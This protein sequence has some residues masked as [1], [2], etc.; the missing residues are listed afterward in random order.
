MKNIK[1]CIRADF[2]C[3]WS[4]PDEIVTLYKGYKKRDIQINECL[5]LFS[6]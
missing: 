5:F 6:T 4:I 2:F 1:G 3:L